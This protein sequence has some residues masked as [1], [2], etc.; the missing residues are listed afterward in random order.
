MQHNTNVNDFTKFTIFTC[1]S[2]SDSASQDVPVI[3]ACL[4]AF[5][6][7]MYVCM[8][9]W[10]TS[11]MAFKNEATITGRV[12]PNVLFCDLTVICDFLAN[13]WS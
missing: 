2:V 1:R 8:E 5:A 6:D 7:N 4:A 3:L 12:S 13:S 11:Y 9:T 10:H